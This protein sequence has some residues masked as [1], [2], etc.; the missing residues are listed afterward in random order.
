[1]GFEKLKTLPEL[2]VIGGV[3]I[4]L[5]F[6]RAVWLMRVAEEKSYTAGRRICESQKISL[7]S[8]PLPIPLIEMTW[9]DE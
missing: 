5:S 7:R 8:E 4:F 3:L 1:M 9:G 2:H 6:Q